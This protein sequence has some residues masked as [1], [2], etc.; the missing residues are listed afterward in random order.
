MEKCSFKCEMKCFYLLMYT[1]YVTHVIFIA[2]KDL[3]FTYKI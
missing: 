3:N 2:C 1:V